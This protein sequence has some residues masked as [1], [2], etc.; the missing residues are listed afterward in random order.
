[1]NIGFAP[2]AAVPASAA[3]RCLNAEMPPASNVRACGEIRLR[4]ATANL[5]LTLFAA[6]A[7]NAATV[8]GF[9]M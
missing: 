1:M 5:G 4:Q 6:S 9:G 7:I 2:E 8:S 3:R